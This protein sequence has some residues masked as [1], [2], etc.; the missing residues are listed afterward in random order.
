MYADLALTISLVS[1]TVNTTRKHFL[2]LAAVCLFAGH[3]LAGSFVI[4]WTYEYGVGSPGTKSESV[5][6]RL[7][8]KGDELPNE[9]QH[10]ITPIGEF[11]FLDVQGEGSS[12]K[13][14]W[15]PCGKLPG[16]TDGTIH[17]AG[18]ETEM[19]ELLTG[20]ESVF[21]RVI[22]SRAPATAG[23]EAFIAGPLDKVPKEAG[24]DW[25]YVVGKN[26]WV[27]P[28]E[29]GKVLREKMNGKE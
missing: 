6:G 26:L 1:R 21:R 17:P 5:Y 18:T 22:I 24:K 29:I 19:Q 11:V 20:N 9:Y 12:S 15:V 28:R 10:V 25:F 13:I 8:Y 4:D 3:C 16:Y 7:L 2:L 14:A 23:T 27:N